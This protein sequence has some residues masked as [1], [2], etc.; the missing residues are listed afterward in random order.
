MNL[1]HIGFKLIMTDSQNIQQLNFIDKRIYEV[2]KKPGQVHATNTQLPPPSFF[3]WGT[4]RNELC[5][6]YLKN[7]GSEDVQFK[8]NPRDD[9]DAELVGELDAAD[10]RDID[11]LTVGAIKRLNIKVMGPGSTTIRIDGYI[12]SS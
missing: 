2:P 8:I 10:H 11:F 9:S 6:L 3:R 4:S 5:K 12:L 7:Y 1:E